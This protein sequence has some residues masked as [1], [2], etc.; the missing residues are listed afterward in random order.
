MSKGMDAKEK[1][2]AV[3]GLLSEEYPIHGTELIW[4]EPW[5]LLISVM[6][7]AQTTDANVNSVTPRLFAQYPA[8]KDIAEAP[9][10]DLERTVYST[11]Y[12]HAKARN[13]K[14]L[15]TALVERHDGQA[16]ET[17]EELIALPGV[18]RKTANVVLQVWKHERHGIVMDTHISRVTHRLGFIGRKDPVVGE[19]VMMEVLPKEHWLEWGDLLI[20]HGRRVCAAKKPACDRCVLKEICPSAFQFPHFDGN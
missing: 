17:M 16:P 15:C 11:G 20:Q 14:A 5:Q 8:P 18:G 1:A 9:I 13:L 7:S 12:Y 10:E 19:Q 2:L 3:I 6:L 4:H